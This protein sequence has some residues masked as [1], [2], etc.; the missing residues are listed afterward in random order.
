MRF[1]ELELMVNGSQV[2]WR[3]KFTGSSDINEA[4]DNIVVVK[5]DD[6]FKVFHLHLS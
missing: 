6:F 4:D 2:A 3:D 5:Q 1:L